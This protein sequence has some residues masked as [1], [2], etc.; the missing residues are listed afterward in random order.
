M[1][2]DKET[3]KR[4]V[5]SE[6]DATGRCKQCGAPYTDFTKVVGPTGIFCSE[7]CRKQHEAFTERV[8]VLGAHDKPSPGFRGWYR[9]YIR[10]AI[11]LIILVFAVALLATFI[12]VPF[13]TD[14]VSRFPIF[15]Q[16]REMIS[17]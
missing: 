4:R 5:I 8:N 2:E 6:L 14:F 13:L 12:E 7:T 1:S 3:Q 9:A 15:F 10:K 16:I 17:G 11:V